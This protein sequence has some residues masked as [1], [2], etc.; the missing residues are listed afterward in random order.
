VEAKGSGSPRLDRHA[1]T[2]NALRHAA[3]TGDVI[4]IEG[5]DG[6]QPGA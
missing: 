4:I 5:D 1:A 2:A 6:P 3:S